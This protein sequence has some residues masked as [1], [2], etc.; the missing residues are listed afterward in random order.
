MVLVAL[1]L[2]GLLHQ[3]TDQRG[4]A[5]VTLHPKPH[6]LEAEGHH[7]LLAVDQDPVWT[8]GPK[9]R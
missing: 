3:F 2:Q 6:A 8:P 1:V 9:T 4:Q 7:G 5:A